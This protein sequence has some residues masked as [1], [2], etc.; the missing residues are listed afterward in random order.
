LDRR[1]VRRSG[2]VTSV[3]PAELVVPYRPV[4]RSIVKGRTYQAHAPPHRGIARLQT[5]LTRSLV[6][7]STVVVVPPQGSDP[8]QALGEAVG[9]ALDD[10]QDKA[11]QVEQCH[12][13]WAED[14]DDDELRAAFEAAWRAYEVAHQRCLRLP[15][16]RGIE[17][18]PL[19]N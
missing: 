5:V 19:R 3:A 6:S 15:P 11:T 4:L 10:L 9:Q 12:K 1:H 18:E 14:P 2:A 8:G 7:R 16:L 17:P 13:D